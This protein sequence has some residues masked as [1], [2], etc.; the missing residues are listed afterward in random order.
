ML[1]QVQCNYLSQTSTRFFT[2]ADCARCP[3]LQVGSHEGLRV[4]RVADSVGD[5]EFD[6]GME[7]EAGESEVCV[8]ILD[9]E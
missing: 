7:I 1:A 6:D 3:R 9:V 8:P 2:H 4:L 5:A